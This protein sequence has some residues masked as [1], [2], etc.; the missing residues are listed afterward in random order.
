MAR[1]SKRHSMSTFG[2]R[3][4]FYRE[5]AGLTQP[6]L[7]E[8]IHVSRQ[9]IGQW[10]NDERT[11]YKPYIADLS[12]VLGIDEQSLL[13]GT[14]IENQTVADELGLSNDVIMFLKAI[15]KSEGD[16]PFP[17]RWFDGYAPEEEINGTSPINVAGD[18]KIEAV[19]PSEILQLV[20]WLLSHTEGRELLSLLYRYLFTDER[21][22]W[23]AVRS[24]DYQMEKTF[25]PSYE[26]DVILQDKTHQTLIEPELMVFAMKH[27]VDIKMNSIREE[28]KKEREQEK[29]E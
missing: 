24:P 28:I 1:G 26:Y 15:S 4:R 14:P 17:I 22:C 13:I 11:S 8:K 18:Y 6:M 9:I 27:A 29:E 12:R 5:R 3:L 23:L 7:A 21:S 2:G 10:E 16:K 20:N 19:Y 25:Y